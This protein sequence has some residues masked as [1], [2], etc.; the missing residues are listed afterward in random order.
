MAKKKTEVEKI[1]LQYCKDVI[2]NKIPNCV[3][4]KKS[5]KRFISDLKRQDEAGF[6]YIMNWEAVQE[7]ST[8]TKELQLPDMKTKLELLPWQIDRKS[9]V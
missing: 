9:V 2:S 1:V 3:W 6:D 4:A 8:F 5:V 7:F